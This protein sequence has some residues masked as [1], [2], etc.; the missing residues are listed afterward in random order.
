M[1]PGNIPGAVFESRRECDGH[2]RTCDSARKG[3]RF[4]SPRTGYGAIAVAGRN[5]LFYH[6]PDGAHGRLRARVRRNL[7]ARRV[8]DIPY[9]SYVS[10]AD[11]LRVYVPVFQI[12]GSASL[13]AA[14]RRVASS[15]RESGNGAA[16]KKNGRISKLRSC[17]AITDSLSISRGMRR[18]F[19]Y[20]VR[21]RFA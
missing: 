1:Y 12:T 8:G 5:L 4:D 15:N 21:K 19:A 14:L 3:T 20:V 2:A 10:R 9:K 18:D 11:I 16:G 6:C 7:C 13:V 17:F